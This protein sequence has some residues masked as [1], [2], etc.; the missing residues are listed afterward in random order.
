MKSEVHPQPFVHVKSHLRPE[1]AIVFSPPTPQTS[2]FVVCLDF[3]GRDFLILPSLRRG[4]GGWLDGKKKRNCQ[5]VSCCEASWLD[6]NTMK[7]LSDLSG[8]LRRRRHFPWRT[9]H[10]L[11]A[12]L[13]RHRRGGGHSQHTR[14]HFLILH[15]KCCPGNKLSSPFK[16]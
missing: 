9:R 16:F 3:Q 15:R 12:V 13:Q 7:H 5:D 14:T 8:K 4:G 6:A 11:T 2:C 1:D 10:I